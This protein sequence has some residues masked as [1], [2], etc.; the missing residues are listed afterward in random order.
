LSFLKSYRADLKISLAEAVAVGD[1]ANDLPM[2]LEAG[3]GVGY[4]PKP[5]VRERVFNSITHSDLLSILYMQGYSDDE[6]M[7]YIKN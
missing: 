4:R 1:G 6:I 2:L 5:L 3:L 7:P